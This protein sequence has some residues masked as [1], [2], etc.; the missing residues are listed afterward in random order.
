MRAILFDKK[1]EPFRLVERDIPLPVPKD[2]EIRVR[3]K[4]ASINAADWRCLKMGIIPRSGIFGADIS[5]VVDAVG[6]GVGVW[7]EGDSVVADLSN[8]GFGGF[9]EYVCAPEKAF[10]RKPGGLDFIAA[11]AIPLAGVTALQAIRD[12]G[13]LK[14]GQ[15]V[16]VVGASGG[17]GSFAVQIAS[18]MGARVS[19]VTSGKN[20][21]TAAA[22]G[23]QRVIDYTREDFTRVDD[24]FDLIIAVNGRASIRDYSR[25]LKSRG[26][27]VMVGGYLRQVFAALFLG[28]I[29]S[30]GR[31]KHLALAARSNV[32]D[33]AYLLDLAER[34]AITPSI[35]RVYRFGEIPEAM[36]YALKGHSRGKL[37]I[38]Y[39][40]K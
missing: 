4:A 8:Y 37:V 1:A 17:V 27:C 14:D 39:G 24:R 38:D 35:E 36:D 7:K 29:V 40:V 22:L 18:F 3:V 28:P 15:D 33:L 31:K 21:Q 13:S 23:A 34:K 12:K 2:G 9:A 25:L 11:S 10:V 32:E 19:A 5:G 16:L 6:P 26:T 20:A 30:L